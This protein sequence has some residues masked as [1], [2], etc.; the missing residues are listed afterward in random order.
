VVANLRAKR[1]VDAVA[2]TEPDELNGAVVDAVEDGLGLGV[3]IMSLA[4]FV[5]RFVDGGGVVSC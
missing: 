2:S 3:G 5:E 4:G 1:L